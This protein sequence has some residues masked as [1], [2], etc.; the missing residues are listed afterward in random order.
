MDV[1]SRKG[2][3]QP[4]SWRAGDLIPNNHPP[5]EKKDLCAPGAQLCKLTARTMGLGSEASLPGEPP[6]RSSSQLGL[7]SAQYKKHVFP[8]PG[9]G[10][11]F[12]PGGG[13]GSQ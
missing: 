9:A 13:A 12:Q 5:Q 6:A 4:F 1:C 10:P 2:T 11:A 3:N 8:H 7:L